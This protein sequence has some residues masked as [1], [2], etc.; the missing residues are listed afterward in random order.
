MASISVM[1]PNLPSTD[2]VTS[3]PRW[4]PPTGSGRY[5]SLGSDLSADGNEIFLG[6][7]FFPYSTTRVLRVRLANSQD[8]NVSFNGQD[9]APAFETGGSI[10]FVAISS[11]QSVTFSPA[12]GDLGETYQW[13]DT[14]ALLAFGNHVQ[15]LDDRSLIVTF[16]DGVAS[17]PSFSDSTGDDLNWTQNMAITPVTVP[18]ASGSPPPTYATFV[19]TPPA[20][21]TFNSTTRVISGTPTGLGTGIIRI[22]A[23]NS[24][25]HADW[26]VDFTISSGPVA[27]S[28]SDPTGDAQT[29]PVASAISPITVPAASGDPTPTYAVFGSLPDG[30]SFN[31]S[32]RVISGTPTSVSTGTITIRAT[33]SA[34][35]ADWTLAYEAIVPLAAPSF[36]DSTGD[37]QTWT[38]N[39]AITPITVPAA[40]GNPTPTYAAVGSLPS[41]LS[42]N[43]TTRVISGTP[44]A[45]GSGTIRIRATNSQNTADWTVAYTTAAQLAGPSFADPTGDAQTWTQ[46]LA[47]TPITVPAA[48]GNPTPTYAAVG[49]LPSGL[50]FNTS[51]RVISGTPTATG[52]GT[53]RIRATNSQNTADWTVAYTTSAQ[54]VAPSFSDSTGD[55]Q[56]WT[57]NTAIAS[58]TVP[59]ASGSPTPTYAVVG[60]LPSGL[61]FN[62]TTRVISGTPTATGSGTITIRATNSQNTADWT[63]AYT[64]S[65]QSVTPSFSDNTG[66]AQT[67]TQNQAITPITVPAASGTPTPTYAVFVNTPPAGITFNPTT[68]VISGTPTG[69]GSGTIRIR[70]TNSQGHADWTIDFTISAQLV[71]P[72]FA[73]PTG[74]AQTWTVNT[75]IASITVPAASGNPTPTYAVVGSLPSGLSFNTST[76]V[77]SGTPTATGSGTITIRATNSVNTADWAVS[78]AVAAQ[79]VTLTFSGATIANQTYTQG[80]PIANLVLPVATEA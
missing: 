45:T 11:G 6:Y 21:I 30:L 59:A 17:A 47:I 26:T 60:S 37:A 42:F 18:S 63:M 80:T 40:S 5:V 74:D 39:Q 76:R 71:A 41:G 1:I 65:A 55:A 79:S 8:Q 57:V 62:T 13:D 23:T 64:T 33:N 49:S 56:T 4:N 31:T 28:F 53:I 20:G 48:S 43:V 14:D 73:D 15:S 54:L 78:Y 67:W 9:L 38:Q 32:T 19:N 22:R 35:H 44:T 24:Q 27:P 51:T 77:I 72:S 3:A 68:R 70:A 66:D 69:T 10:T 52:S 29:W 25:G 61:S 7:L 50:S 58:I 34:G 75:A 36:P 12:G 16:D 46:N 2:W